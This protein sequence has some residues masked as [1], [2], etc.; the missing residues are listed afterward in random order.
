[1]E[2]NSC[3]PASVIPHH[4]ETVSSWLTRWLGEHACHHS[5]FLAR[6]SRER[7]E[8]PYA[9]R[10]EPDY[11]RVPGWSRALASSAGITPELLDRI[12]WP[13]SP[14]VLMPVARRSVCVACLGEDGAITSQ[15]MRQSWTDSWRT[16]CRTHS[17]PLMYAPAFGWGW[18]Q[19]STE[20]RRAHGAL[21]RKPYTL[22]K[23]IK[24]GWARLPTGLTEAPFDAE[25]G[26]LEAWGEHYSRVKPEDTGSSGNL[27]IWEDL[28]ALC[29]CNWAPSTDE[30]PATASLPA[31]LVGRNRFFRGL[32]LP[33]FQGRCDLGRFR[34]IEDPAVR[35][36]ALLC[37]ADAMLDISSRPTNERSRGGSSWGWRRVAAILPPLAWE[38]LDR[39]SREWPPSWRQRVQDW[40]AVGSG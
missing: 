3:G 5:E 34:S 28:L 9:L 25:L 40:R 19:V 11:P 33:A 16:M 1:M 29:T 6:L 15:Y 39:R 4:D 8:L 20:V 31:L 36:T 27:R 32:R 22:V 38:W 24:A 26:L 2:T 10:A 30:I 12:A 7:A 35:R 13:P 23:E 14:W 21:M 17:L 37:V 18:G